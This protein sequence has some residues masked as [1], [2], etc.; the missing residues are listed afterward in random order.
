MKTITLTLEVSDSDYTM[1]ENLAN[2]ADY[3]IEGYL[4]NVL[5][6]NIGLGFDEE[7]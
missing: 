6:E 3:S 1:I 7:E 2:S 4:H 5:S